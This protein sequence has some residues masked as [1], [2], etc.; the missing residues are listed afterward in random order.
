[1]SDIKE[2]ID[3][4]RAN[5]RAVCSTEGSDSAECAVAWDTVEELQAEASHQKTNEVKKTVL[6]KFCDDN[7]DADECRIYE[8]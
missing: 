5:A 3:Q 8:D 2:K 6:E 7:P 1:M 4:E